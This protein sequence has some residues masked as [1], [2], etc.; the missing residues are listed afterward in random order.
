MK[1]CTTLKILKCKNTINLKLSVNITIR[2]N[3]VR[4]Y[5]IFRIS[6][7]CNLGV[8]HNTITMTKFRE[9]IAGPMF[10]F[11]NIQWVLILA[12][13]VKYSIVKQSYMTHG[14]GREMHKSSYL[15]ISEFY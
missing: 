3:I 10:E 15:K 7:S 4:G 11:T 9:F 8:L 12:S 1:F 6:F 13:N 2:I 14:M 5:T